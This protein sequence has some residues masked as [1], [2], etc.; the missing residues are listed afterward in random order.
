MAFLL[1]KKKIGHFTIATLPVVIISMRSAT[2]LINLVLLLGC[3][4][5]TPA[6]A[7]VFQDLAS[8]ITTPAKTWLI[9]GT[10]LTTVLLL[11]E[12]QIVDPAQKET[13][14]NHPLGRFSKFGDYGGKLIPNALYSGGM[15][16]ASALGSEKAGSKAR[17]MLLATV[18]SASAT[19]LIKYSAREPRPNNGSDKKS[20][21]SGHSTTAFAFASVVGAE[22]GWKWGIP[23]YAL[24]GLVAYSRM[25]DNQHYL[26]DVV[27]GATIGAAYG[28]G[29][30]Y[31]RREENHESTLAIL[32][33][34]DFKSKGILVALRF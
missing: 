11:F 21:P 30:H 8:P 31:L 34:W 19:T 5:S 13:I 18:Y 14:E 17:I 1:Q 28:L 4:N 33:I 29:I 2:S 26:H 32:P 3:I 25:N 24:A 27:A 23:A 6:N 7:T 12:D 10:A 22:E 15:F 16:L 9:A 20:F